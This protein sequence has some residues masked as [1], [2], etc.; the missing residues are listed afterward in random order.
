M[1]TFFTDNALLGCKWTCGLFEVID[2]C[3]LPINCEGLST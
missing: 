1:L 2:D 3:A